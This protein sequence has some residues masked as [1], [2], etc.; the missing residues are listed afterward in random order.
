MTTLN[1]TEPHYIRCI[2]PNNDKQSDVIVGS[3]VLQQLT[4][5]GVFEAVSIR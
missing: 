2:K 5:S 1:T 4:Y 3:L